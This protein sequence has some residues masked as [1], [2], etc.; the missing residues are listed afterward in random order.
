MRARAER[1]R[2]SAKPLNISDGGY[3]DE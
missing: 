2:Q 1:E 3:K